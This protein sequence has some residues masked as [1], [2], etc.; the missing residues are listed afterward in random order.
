MTRTTRWM[1]GAALI[2]FMISGAARAQSMRATVDTS[3]PGYDP[4][5]VPGVVRAQGLVSILDT[6]RPDYDPLGIYAGAFNI[7]PT[8]RLGTEYN[9]NIYATDSDR[10]SDWI[11]LVNPEVDVRS[12]WS[13][14][15][16]G[17]NAALLTGFYTSNSD[18]NWLDGQIFL[19]GRVDVQRESFFKIGAGF[20]RLHEER[21]S[22]ESDQAWDE[23]ARYYRTSGNLSY[24]LG[25]N[26]F[27]ITAGAGMANLDWK[28]VDLR[29]GGSRSLDIRDR[30]LYDVNA[31]IAY[32]LNPDVQP[33][34]TT[35]Y[36]WRRYDKSEAERDSRGYRIGIGTGFAITSVISGEIFGGYMAQ[37][38][39]D[40]E[41][42]YGPW[43]GM[44]LL[45]N[46]TQLTSVEAGA[47]S[48]IKET[49][50]EDASGIDAVEA[51]IRIDHELLR[52]LLVGAFLKYEQYDYQDEDINDKYYSVGPS[53]TY[54]WNRN[55]SARALYSYRN[56][57]SD[58]S[59][60]EFYENR[61]LVSISGHF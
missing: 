4:L 41:N 46:P 42:I 43:Y 59:E 17:L 55:L 18:E 45:W 56:K 11:M 14:H 7:K 16:L 31:R 30:N 20:E 38:Y 29:E 8:L 52:N 40:R 49:F 23:P 58:V 32:E 36:E 37:N 15:S 24:A 39:D 28:S 48:S 53:L 5:R 9:D 57:N 47:Q 54:F 27:S 3:R 26:R 25:L 21:G 19:D 61:F 10:E 12:D 50:Q 35:R 1:L 22:P 2:V 60:R 34:L 44:S 6:P 13:R 51:G 33:F